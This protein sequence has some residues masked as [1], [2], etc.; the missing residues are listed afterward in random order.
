MSSHP[1]SSLITQSVLFFEKLG[2][3]VVEGPEIEEEKFNFDLLNI[4]KDHPARDLQDT[5]YLNDGRLLRTHTSAMQVKTVWQ[6]KPPCRILIPG[7]V[8][9]H[10]ATDATHEA[11]FF[12]LEGFAIEKNLTLAHL[13]W[14]LESYLKHIFGPKIQVKIVPHYYPFVEPGMDALIKLK[15]GKWLEVL[16]A[17][18]IHPKVLKNMKLDPEKWRGFA[19]GLGIDRLVM[20]KHG[21]DDIRLFYSND[22]RF[23]KQFK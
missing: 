5:F 19:F 11:S 17:G 4:G 7:R 21:I 6:K 20:L 18:M 2:F 12:Q 13:K 9:R 16:G 22:L 10:E 3:E 14:V 15:A 23:L 1:L 8:F